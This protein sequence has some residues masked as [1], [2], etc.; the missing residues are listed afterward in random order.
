MQNC[1]EVGALRS[2]AYVCPQGE[3]H[4]LEL[5]VSGVVACHIRLVMLAVV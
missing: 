3:V 4:L 1:T 2:R 5:F